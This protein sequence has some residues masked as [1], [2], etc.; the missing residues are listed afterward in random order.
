MSQI[1]CNIPLK[2][3]KLNVDICNNICEFTF[4]QTYIN[5]ETVPVEVSYI[6]PSMADTCVYD[7]RAI[8]DGTTII[9]TQIKPKETAVKEYNEA[10]RDGKQTILMERLDG[11]TFSV[12]L[13]N[14]PPQATAQIRIRCV[15]E[16]QTEIDAK[17]LRINVPL[18]IMPKYTPK[19][20]PSVLSNALD[21]VTKVFTKPYDFKLEGQIFMSDGIVSLD[22]KTHKIKISN[23][24]SNQLNFEINPENLN[25]DII[26][27]IARN[28]PE[29]FIVCE[30]AMDLPAGSDPM[31][32]YV[33]QVNIIPD[34][35]VVPETTVKDMTYVIILDRSGS[36][37]G[38]DF[39]NAIKSAVIFVSALP[40]DSKFNIYEFGSDY[41]K[42]SPEMTICSADSKQKAV[43]WLKT[44]RCSGGTEVFG[45]M[46]DVYRTL[47]TNPGTII[48]LSDGGVSNTEKIIKLVKANK[49]IGIYTI[50]IG[51]D[52]SQE[53]IKEMAVSSGGKSEFINSADDQIREK[54]L[55]QL[56]RSQQTMRKCQQNNKIRVDTT[57]SYKMVPE[58]QNLYEGDV[59]T[60]YIFSSEPIN[61]VSY[62]QF[63]PDG[64]L[65]NAATLLA[66]FPLPGTSVHRMAGVKLIN[67]TS[68]EPGGSQIARLQQDLA[69]DTIISISQ[70]LGILSKYTAF[71][72]VEIKQ[73]SS[74]PVPTPLLKQVPLQQPKKYSGQLECCMMQS[75]S[76]S[77]S[78]PKSMMLSADTDD[79]ENEE[80][81][82]A[83]GF[84]SG[85]DDT[86]VQYSQKS[87]SIQPSGMR[88][89]LS[90]A[91]SLVG[92]GG[93]TTQTNTT[94]TP[95]KPQV[96]VSF[97][98]K[99]K[100][101]DYMLLDTVL[102]CTK[103][104][105][106]PF[107][108]DVK[109]GDYVELVLEDKYNGVYKVMSLGSNDSPWMLEKY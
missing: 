102:S 100:L 72:G 70:S 43:G 91:M 33:S 47:K 13:G 49:N 76:M 94:K 2:A 21:S 63:G 82:C 14:V 95:V 96:T 87:A 53:L 19:A 40:F 88:S 6:Y 30:S 109:I 9:E 18:T 66:S 10:I 22:S 80:E 85:W 52:V 90:N 103:N 16:L 15:A 26:L 29:S 44:L 28:E 41:T 98:V 25:E 57:G 79:W 42:F 83:G 71:I 34:Y 61:S 77:R 64:L 92:F 99:I 50:G 39:N 37:E 5:E 69:K 7:F 35:T 1:K 24:N 65:Q 54:V 55:V 48:F 20:E 60:F 75:A 31:Y 58:V 62:D 97:V 108:S 73:T 59:N 101:T 86:S 68:N 81:D 4:D 11:D 32:K 23:M 17:N 84:D 67:M 45:V 106:L 8:I 74:G 105:I 51:Q 89:F 107:A 93:A 12:C 46:E 38:A 3:V 56:K 27:S 78:M 104:V 36:M